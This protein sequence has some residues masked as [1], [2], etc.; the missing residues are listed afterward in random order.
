M[1]YPPRQAADSL[2]VKKALEKVMQ[3]ME[4]PKGNNN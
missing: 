1:E 4:N 2:S 3:Q